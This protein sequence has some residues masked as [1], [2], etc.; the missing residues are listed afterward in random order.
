[1]EENPGGT[2]DNV[3]EFVKLAGA[4]IFRSIDPWD[5]GGGGRLKLAPAPRAG[6]GLRSFE[7]PNFW[8]LLSSIFSGGRLNGGRPCCCGGFTCC[9][10]DAPG[11]GGAEPCG[12]GGTFCRENLRVFK[13]VNGTGGGDVVGGGPG[14]CENGGGGR[15]T[16][17]GGRD[18]GR[19]AMLASLPGHCWL[20]SELSKIEIITTCLYH[21]T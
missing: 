2:G 15:E 9:K 13:L 8:N 14:T 5:D 10:V 16:G 20:N 7:S 11:P 4:L 3:A 17:G 21:V 19:L 6:E 1:M 12:G 18:W